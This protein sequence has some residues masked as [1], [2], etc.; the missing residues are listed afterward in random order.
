MRIAK[1]AAGI[2]LFR[3]RNGAIEVLLV[4]PGG[5]FWAKRDEGA[6]SVPK[7]ELEGDEP[8]LTAAHREFVEELGSAPRTSGT[9]HELQPV[10]QPG[11]KLVL[12]WAQEG[13]F[14]LETLVSNTFELEWPP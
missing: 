7:G 2:L 13:D 6:W 10:L 5:P 1:R 3:R 9:A 4:H 8:P 11:G 12:A 14:E